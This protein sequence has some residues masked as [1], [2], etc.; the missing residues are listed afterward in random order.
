LSEHISQLKPSDGVCCFAIIDLKNGKD[1]F[2]AAAENKF[3]KFNDAIVYYGNGITDA[4]LS[5]INMRYASQ[6][7]LDALQKARADFRHMLTE[8][9]SDILAVA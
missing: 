4:E 2:F 5:S 8:Q 1:E 6:S 9:A 7:V 3:V